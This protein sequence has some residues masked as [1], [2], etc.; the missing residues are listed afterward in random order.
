MHGPSQD[1]TGIAFFAICSFAYRSPT[2]QNPLTP[3]ASSEKSGVYAFMST[4]AGCLFHSFRRDSRGKGYG[5]LAR[6]KLDGGDR[7]AVAGELVAVVAIEAASPL[8]PLSPR[9]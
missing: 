7:L 1:R 4:S 3:C 8:P 6:A 2:G 5:L 9:F